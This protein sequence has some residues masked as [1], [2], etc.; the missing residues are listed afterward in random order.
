MIVEEYF[1]DFVRRYSDIGVMIKQKQTNNI[2]SE[3]I[4]YKNSGYTYEET[5]MPVSD[6]TYLEKFSVA[7]KISSLELQLQELMETN[8]ML[9]ECLLDMSGTVYE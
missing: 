6:A 5:T 4:D 2:Y 9:T 3:A 8:N 7:E 1:S